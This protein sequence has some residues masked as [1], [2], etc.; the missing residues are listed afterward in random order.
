[1]YDTALSKKLTELAAKTRPGDFFF[2]AA[3]LDL[4][5]PLQLRNGSYFEALSPSSTTTQVK[6]VIDALER[7]RVKYVL[8]SARLDN[9]SAASTGKDALQPVHTYLKE[10]YRVVER[11]AP[12]D[13]LWERTSGYPAQPTATGS[14]PLDVHS[15]VSNLHPSV[16]STKVQ[17][18]LRSGR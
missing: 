15:E 8:W 13:N 18:P 4:Y 14:L 7:H 12:A 5:F 6:N 17:R 2:Q 10:N 16:K 9:P 11:F 3:W 1:V